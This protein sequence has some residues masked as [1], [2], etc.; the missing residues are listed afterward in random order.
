MCQNLPVSAVLVEYH[1]IAMK[2]E[3]LRTIDLS[4]K[5]LFISNVVLGTRKYTQH[6]R[7]K[8]KS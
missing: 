7:L 3:N 8:G 2:Y 6:L 1:V 5:P 4:Y